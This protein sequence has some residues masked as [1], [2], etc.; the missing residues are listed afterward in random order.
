[1]VN[2]DKRE[3]TEWLNY[4]IDSANKETKRVLLIGDSIARAIRKSLNESLRND[5]Y[6]VDL[7]ATSF[8][9]SENISFKVLVDFFNINCS[10]HYDYIFFNWGFHHGY[11]IQC[12][13][14]ENYRIR[15]KDILDYL[16]TKCCHIYFLTGTYENVKDSPICVK[17]NDEINQRSIIFKDE[18]KTRKIGLVDL[19]VLQQENSNLFEYID[20]F[21]FRKHSYDFIANELKKIIISS[22]TEEYFFENVLYDTMALKQRI[23]SSKEIYI[24]GN[25]V[26]GNALKSFLI[27][28]GYNISGI[29]V[30]Q[31]YYSGEKGL[32]CFDDSFV[33]NN[34]DNLIIVSTKDR[35]VCK[36][37]ANANMNYCTLD[38]SLY[39]M[40]YSINQ[41]I[42]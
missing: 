22:F 8:E 10:Y 16:L 1:M 15:I 24:Y 6:V 40:I 42:N 36:E 12:M 21:H 7:L 35:N 28:S 17:H 11:Y 30:S 23:M 33:R 41:L 27:L 14:D 31:E 34:N 20:R 2:I 32:I 29:L 38:A 9:V 26:R 19:S 37:L 39:N 5:G 4:W 13:D 18:C 3:E 25:G